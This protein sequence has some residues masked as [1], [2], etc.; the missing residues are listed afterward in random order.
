MDKYNFMT[1]LPENNFKHTSA[2]ASNYLGTF[3]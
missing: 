1:K 2:D 3:L